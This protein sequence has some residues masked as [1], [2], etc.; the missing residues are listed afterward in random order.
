MDG[1]SVTC[2]SVICLQALAHSCWISGQMRKIH[3]K[4][5]PSI[6]LRVPKRPRR[7]LSTAAE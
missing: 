2:T 3:T 6:V 1:L 4:E 7:M 5:L